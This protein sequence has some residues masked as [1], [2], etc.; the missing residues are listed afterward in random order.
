MRLW[1]VEKESV[2]G[3]EIAITGDD[4]RHIVTVL[5]KKKG[6][7]IKVALPDNL[8]YKAKITTAG[9]DKVIAT[10][11]WKPLLAQKQAVDF[12]LALSICK[13]SVME[14][15]LQKAV[16]LG[17]NSFIP[18]VTAKSLPKT[19]S[20]NKLAR[21]KKIAHESYKQSGRANQIKICKPI[22]ID[23]LPSADFRIVL[24]ED[25]TK[26][27]LKEVLQN[28][29]GKPKSLL[30]IVGPTAGFVKSEVE[31]LK[32]TGFKTARCGSLIMRAET[33]GIALVA[34]LNYHFNRF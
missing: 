2:N 11:K 25:E 29:K 21:L 31:K 27:T 28:Y 30:A 24:W 1:R 4:A 13:P 18:I 20:D 16:E 3:R 5:R 22:T 15:T 6:D 8:L 33:A 17:V 32:E 7:V 26:E 10:L 12:A 34:I 14:I 23:E 9:K 19:L